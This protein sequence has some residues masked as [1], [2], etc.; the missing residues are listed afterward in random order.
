MADP[1]TLMVGAAVIG[2]GA[3]VGSGVMGYMAGEETAAGAERTA[4]AGL[5][6]AEALTMQGAAYETQ[7][8]AYIAQ[9][10]TAAQVG[11]LQALAA[12]VQATSIRTQAAGQAAAYEH[13]ADKADSIAKAA[14]T[15]ADQTDGALRNELNTTLKNIAAVR[16]AAGADPYSPTGLALMDQASETSEGTRLIALD[17]ALKQIG[18]SVSDAEYFRTAAA[19]AIQYGEIGVA[20]AELSGTA[21]LV[22]SLGQQVASG[23]AAEGALYSAAGSYASANAAALGSEAAMYSGSAASYAGLGSLLSGIGTAGRTLTGL[24][25]TTTST[26]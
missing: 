17:N 10:Q 1:V 22:A 3:S 23:L 18:L 19:M 9:G 5:M 24:R 26:T 25:T 15:A 21:A 13:E 12:D 7:A 4:A 8:A 11:V 14:R 2:A 6:Q 16:V 20:G